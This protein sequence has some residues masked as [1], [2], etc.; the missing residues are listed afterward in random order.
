LRGRS[1]GL[2]LLLS[3]GLLVTLTIYTVA[4]YAVFP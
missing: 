1:Y 3:T 2:V 4:S